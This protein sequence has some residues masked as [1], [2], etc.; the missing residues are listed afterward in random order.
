MKTI[1]SN[2][3]TNFYRNFLFAVCAVFF[4]NVNVGWGQTTRTWSGSTS[5]AWLTATNWGTVP[6][7]FNTTGNNDIAYFNNNTNTGVVINMNNGSPKGEYY[8]GA[9]NYG[10]SATTARTLTNSAGSQTGNMYFNSVTL[11]SIANTIIWNQSSVTHTFSLSSPNINFVL[12]NTTDNVI[13]ITGTGGYTIASPITGSNKLTKAGSGAGVLTLSGVN[14]YSGNTTISEGT[15]ALSGSGSIANSPVITI[16][17]GATFNVSGLTTA[18]AL[19]TPQSISASATGSNTTGTLT[20]VSGKGLT[21]S[22]GG[23]SFSAYGGGA[24]APITVSGVSAGSLVLNSAPVTVATTTALAAG[25]Y[26]LVAKGGSATVTGTPGTLT[27]GGSGLASGTTGALSVVSGELIL[28]VSI[29]AQ[30]VTFDANGGTGSMSNQSASTATALTNNS[31]TRA[32]YN[33]AGWNTIAGGGGTAYANGASFPFTANTTLY[34]QWTAN[35]LTVTYDSQGGSAITAGSTTTGGTIASSPGTPTRAGYTFNGWFAASSGGSAITFPYTHGQTANFTL[36]AQWTLIT[37]TVTFNSNGGAGSMSNQTAAVATNLTTNAY[38]R[39][40]YTFSGWNTASNGSGT[41]YANSASYAFTASTTLYAQWTVV[42]TPTI[43]IS[44]TLSALST[45]Y[46]TASSNT[47]FSVSGSALTNDIIVTPPAVFEVSL[48]AASGFGTSLTLTQTAG[49]VSSTTIYVRLASTT[50]AGTY[51]GNIVLSSTGATNVSVATVSSTVNPATLTVTGLSASGKTYDGNTTVSVSGTAAFSGLQNGDSFTPSGSVTWVFPSANIGLQTLTRTGTYTLA[52]SNYTITQPSLTATITAK[53]L[54]ITSATGNNKV[55]DNTTTATFIGTLTGVVSPDV[56]TFTGSGTFASVNVGTGIAITSTA[57]LGGA[58][59]ANYTLAQ[60]TG[61]AANITAKSLT[62]TANNVTKEIGATLTNGTGSIDFISSGLLAGQTIG[63]VTITYGAGAAAGDAVGSYSNQVTPSAATGGTFLAS[64]YSISYTS[65]NITI[66]NTTAVVIS[67]LCSPFTENFNTLASSGAS[68]A[69][70]TGWYFIESGSNSDVNYTAGTGSASAGD[71]YSFGTAS[72]SDRS[73][74]GVQSGTLVPTVGAKYINSTGS[75]INALTISY[76]GETWR[77]GA[78][79]RSDRLDFQYSTNA[80]SLTTGTWTDVDNLDYTNPGQATGSGSLQHSASISSGISSLSIAN[81]AT[82]WIRW[83]DLNASG[84]DDGMGVDDFSITAC[85]CASPDALAFVQQPTNVSQGLAMAPSVTVK[86]ICSSSG[87]TA[88]SYTG[89]ITLTASG[90]GCGYVSQTVTAVNGVATFNNI[91]FTRSTQTGISLTASASTLTDVVSS[92]FNVTSGGGISTSTDIK[93]DNFSGSTPGWSWSSGA[94]SVGSGGTSGSDVTGV[95]TAGS[96]TYL[97]KSYSA[98][99]T[100]SEKGTKTTITFANTTSLSSYNTLKFTFKIASLNSSGNVSACNGCGVDGPDSL[101]IETSVDGGTSW[102]RILTHVGASDKLFAFGGSVLS[103]TYGTNTILSASSTQSAFSVSIPSGTS[104]FQ[105]RMIA[106][107]NRTGENWCIDD[108]KLVGESYSG[109]V[110]SPLPTVSAFGATNICVGGSAYLY[111]SLSNT[112]GALTY[113]WASAIGLSATNTSD[114]TA[115]LNGTQSYTV[116]VTDGDNCIASSSAVTVTVDSPSTPA[117]DWLGT[118]SNDWFDCR[119]WK[120]KEVPSTTTDVTI[121]SGTPYAPLISQAG[122]NCRALTIQ[123]AATLTVNDP[124]SALDVYGAYTN[125]GAL[126]HTN[127]E[128][129]LTGTAAYNAD[130]G[131][132]SPFYNLKINNSSSE[133]ITLLNKDMVVSNQ[134]SLLD[135]VIT[136]NNN[137]VILTSTNASDMLH[138][139]G[140]SSF[141]FGTL[142]RFIASNTSVYELPVGLSS[143]TFGYRRA[144]IINNNLSG[145][146]FIDASVRLIPETANNIDSRL[147]TTQIGSA[148]TDVLGGSVWSFIPNTQPSDGTYGVK[149]YVAN[150]GLSA[151]DDNTFCPVKR[152][153]NSTDYAD[154]NTFE[155]TTAIPSL[156]SQGRIYDSGNGYAQRL[157]YSSFSEHAFG[158]TPSKEP[159]PVELTLFDASCQETNDAKI[160]WTTASEKNS[161]YFEVEVSTDLVSWSEVG[162]IDAAGNSSSKREYTISD[163]LSRGLRYYRLVQVDFDGKHRTY[164]PVSLNCGGSESV[165]LIYPNPTSGDFVVSIQNEK[166]SGEIAVT[167][168][169]ADGKLISTKTSEATSGVQSIYFENN[170]LPAG[171]YFVNVSDQSGNQLSGKIVVR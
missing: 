20:V 5:T 117:G 62:I 25:T 94:V 111:S 30:T 137:K 8:L 76:T 114:V 79:S 45:T 51:S 91:V 39:S 170:L 80:T 128:I 75:T 63:S 36:Y 163:N 102:Q 127:G 119:N 14:T 100:S 86:A 56:V 1:L 69:T 89:N 48:S 26:K 122:A 151:A 130:C 68:S 34:A 3:T 140:N 134:L 106:R 104:Q 70:P 129:T 18:L 124:S 33:F 81:G 60:P 112:V 57:T 24:T 96:N 55:Y 22:A 157:G 28:T 97:R 154:W 98:N 95:I 50:N 87:G 6:G 19:G 144:D 78:A 133:G 54:T 147:S 123:N 165:F 107:N 150:T 17:S 125:N 13:Q 44:G 65:G 126:S 74:G 10:T 32:G 162:Q 27:V 58:G 109:A 171:I 35:T 85:Q 38:T 9:I 16:A 49:V 11:N 90:G 88:N 159:L 12:N 84:S 2:K 4:V 101:F 64:N 143:E 115:T 131:T 29:A 141:I 139:T 47:T 59:A 83:S 164:D 61:I 71:S 15:L 103:L 120:G 21:L 169:T 138:S 156:G 77:V 41:V 73:F 161:D 53:A 67:S 82:F 145:L 153:D 108:V 152:N 93:N 37:Y 155:Q 31:F 72:N 118:Y 149:L 92:T 43:S 7:A 158:K 40:G 110:T 113:N 66:Q 105:F 167:L 121:L 52:S 99:N 142:R 23:L 116:T 42:S 135:G 132:S 168:N 166:L 148:L 46:G 136:T 160:N 146:T